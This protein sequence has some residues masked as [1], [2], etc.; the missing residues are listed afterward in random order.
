MGAMWLLFLCAVYKYSYLFTV[1]VAPMHTITGHCL[2]TDT[3]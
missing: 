2:N 1:L 3:F